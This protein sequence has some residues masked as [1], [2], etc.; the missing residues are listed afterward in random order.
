VW[1]RISGIKP[2]FSIYLYIK[3]GWK[4]EFHNGVQIIIKYTELSKE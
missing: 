1:V 4:G 3:E 2:H